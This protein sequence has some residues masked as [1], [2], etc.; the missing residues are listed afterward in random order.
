[1]ALTCVIAVL[2]SCGATPKRQ[3]TVVPEKSKFQE[4]EL[5]IP[6][7]V[8]NNILG[9]DRIQ[10]Y[11]VS[12]RT[13]ISFIEETLVENDGSGNYR[14]HMKELFLPAGYDGDM[15]APGDEFADGLYKTISI[16]YPGDQRNLVIEYEVVLKTPPLKKL[17]AG[18]VPNDMIKQSILKI[19]VDNTNYLRVNTGSYKGY[20]VALKDGVLVPWVDTT[21]DPLGRTPDRYYFKLLKEGDITDNRLYVDD[22]GYLRNDN[23]DYVARGDDENSIRYI[24]PELARIP[25]GYIQKEVVPEREEFGRKPDTN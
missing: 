22:H 20:Y 9:S 19:A 15:L 12:T 14:F 16:S 17:K 24:G 21:A 11:E 1:M 6:N 13:S 10:G 3:Q 2:I 7:L 18:D 4:I 5:T 23:D 8:K 25:L